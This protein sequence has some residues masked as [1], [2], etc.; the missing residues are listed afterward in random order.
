MLPG[1]YGFGSAVAEYEK[2]HGKAGMARLRKFYKQSP[3]L[4]TLLSNV[5]MVLAKSDLAVASRYAGLV[6][7]RKLAKTIFT[8]ISDEW[9][10]TA[11]ALFSISGKKEFLAEN[12]GLA[13]SIKNRS[14]YMDPL[15]HL[16]VE[17]IRRHR[18]GADDDRIRRGIHLTI[19]GVAAGL[20]NSG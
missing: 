10:L 18:E 3:F 13:R 17:L 5:D 16:Q 9:K 20:R 8:R 6:K 4:Q 2:K 15:N 7:N 19:N 1:W 14:A 11:R 12:P